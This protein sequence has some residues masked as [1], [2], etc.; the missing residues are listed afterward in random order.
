MG[1]FPLKPYL[2]EIKKRY[3][4]N[5]DNDN[6][7]F[8][9]CSWVAEQ[10]D[11]SEFGNIKDG[12]NE[13]TIYIDVCGW[14]PYEEDQHGHFTPDENGPQMGGYAIEF[15][16]L[17]ELKRLSIILNKS[18]AI[19]QKNYE[20]EENIVEGIREFTIYEFFGA[21]LSELTFCGLPDDRTEQRDRIEEDYN[22]IAK[23]ITKGEKVGVSLDELKKEL[24][25]NK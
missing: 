12:H 15:T 4:S 21:I 7:K 9:R 19:G 24:D 6:I 13:I 8:L 10:F 25:D 20:G 16:R 11:Y 1:H 2:E 5:K 3:K 14:G 17:N 22:D 23:R 18:F